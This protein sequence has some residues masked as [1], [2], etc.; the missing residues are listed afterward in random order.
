[1]K[2]LT[3][4]ERE[5]INIYIK[6]GKDISD[7]IKDRDIK[8]ENFNRA[9]IAKLERTNDDISGCS[10]AFAKI[11]SPGYIVKILE[12]KMNN[13][14]FECA[15]FLGLA[16]IRSCEAKNCNFKGA[17][18]SKVDYRYTNFI[19]STFCEAVIKISTRSGIGCTFPKSMF[20]ELC[21]GWAFKIKIEDTENKEK[22]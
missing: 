20:E 15:E 4:D 7:L 22:V 12:T 11:G 21:K 3:H 1:M 14:N 5:M 9:I 19:G 2:K 10:F 13:C 8:G 18:V 16:W 6:N 17:D